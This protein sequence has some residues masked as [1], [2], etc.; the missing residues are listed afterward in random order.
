MAIRELLFQV[1]F[2]YSR[3]I[4]G[5]TRS[6]KQSSFGNWLKSEDGNSSY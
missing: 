2:I 1:L 3:V 4:S 6:H 5:Y